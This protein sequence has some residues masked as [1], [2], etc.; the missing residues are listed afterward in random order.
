MIVTPGAFDKKYELISPEEGGIL[1]EGM[2][3]MVLHLQNS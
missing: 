2:K 1:G 3:L